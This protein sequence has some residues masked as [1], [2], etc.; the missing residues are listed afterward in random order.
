MKKPPSLTTLALIT[1]LQTGFAQYEGWGRSGS[2]HILTTPDGANLPATAEVQ[3]FPIL[4]RLDRDWFDFKQPKSDGSDLRFSAAG[5]PLAFQIEQWDVAQGAASI[6]VRIPKIK[7]NERKKIEMHWGKAG[8]AGESNGKAVFDESNG[9]MSIMSTLG[10]V[11]PGGCHFPLIGWAQFANLIQPLIERDL[12][13]S[14]PAQSITPPN[15]KS[16]SFASAARDTISLEFDQPVVWAE[17]LSGQFYL[18]GE[19]DK[20]ASGSVIGNRLTLK[21]IAASTATRITYL[22]EVAWKQE[23]LLNGTN[24]IAALTFCDVP[25]VE[26]PR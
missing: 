26:T 23:T 5:K 20:V 7:G 18:D 25:I 22:K 21:L 24:G 15:L 8:A 6:W 2:L 14:R 17:A 1:L 11:P 12:Y 3:D 4:V 16:A 19:K 9:Y 10:I 13:G